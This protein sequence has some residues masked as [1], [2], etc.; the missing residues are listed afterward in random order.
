MTTATEGTLI[1][2]AKSPIFEVTPPRRPA[3]MPMQTVSYW[4][5]RAVVVAMLHG[6]TEG[7]GPHRV[8]RRAAIPV[9]H[10]DD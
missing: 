7:M 10:N 1:V 4:T 2:A 6:V 3:P 8:L 5:P 9:T